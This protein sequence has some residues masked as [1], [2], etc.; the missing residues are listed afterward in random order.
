MINLHLQL[1]ITLS[2]V[3]LSL[4]LGSIIIVFSICFHGLCLLIHCHRFHRLLSVLLDSDSLFSAVVTI[5]FSF[6]LIRF[7]NLSTSS[8]SISSGSPLDSMI[9]F[10]IFNFRI[11]IN[12]IRFIVSFCLQIHSQI[13]YHYQSFFSS[14]SEMSSLRIMPFTLI[15]FIWRAFIVLWVEVFGFRL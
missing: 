11:R 7:Q 14:S 3:S 15:T 6:R 9:G 1:F 8:S 2:F 4:R 12:N 5:I 10:I 13:R